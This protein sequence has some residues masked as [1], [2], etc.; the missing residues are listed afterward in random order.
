MQI[1]MILFT[2]TIQK[3]VVTK[4][5]RIARWKREE[6]LRQMEL[7]RSLRDAYLPTYCTRL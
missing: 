1:S 2:I 5:E 4:A 7:E 3:K 6:R